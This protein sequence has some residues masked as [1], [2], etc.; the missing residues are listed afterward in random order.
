M[1]LLILVSISLL[2]L[3]VAS[4]ID[5]KTKEVP[6][7][8]SYSLIAISLGI[9]VI[10]SVITNNPNIIL[11]GLLGLALGLVLGSLMYYTKQWGGGDAKLLIGITIIYIHYPSPLQIH[12]LALIFFNI[13]LVGAIYSLAWCLSLFIKHRKE[14][15]Q[16]AKQLLKE[17][18]NIRNTVVAITILSAIVIIPLDFSLKNIPFILAPLIFYGLFIM[19]KSVEAVVFYKK[20]PVNKLTEG[21]WITKDIIIQNKVLYKSSSP[22]VTRE[23]IKILKQHNIKEVPIKE[24]IPFV[25]VF[26]LAVVLSLIVGSIL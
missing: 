6:D 20:I 15:T 26:F 2:W 19:V 17:S 16:K 9:E 7:W 25:P 11:L 12:F 14:C 10:Y 4:I 22:G 8:L 18:K 3:L 1:F 5:G 21:D 13:I 24:G 23:Q